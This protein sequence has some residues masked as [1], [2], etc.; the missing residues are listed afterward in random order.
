MAVPL[1][2]K[3]LG[4]CQPPQEEDEE[5]VAAVNLFVQVKRNVNELHTTGF[6]WN[7][8]HRTLLRNMFEVHCGRGNAQKCTSLRLL[9]RRHM[10]AW[11]AR[12]RDLHSPATLSL[13]LYNS[14]LLLAAV[15]SGLSISGEIPSC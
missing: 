9:A 11:K 14:L 15:V 10:L 7:F 13:L 5:K 3:V 12:G 4:C 6:L 2:R 1:Y 8:C